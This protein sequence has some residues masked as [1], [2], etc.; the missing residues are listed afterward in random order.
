MNTISHK[1]TTAGLCVIALITAMMM[2]W[3]ASTF[4]TW[5]F[6]IACSL[7]AMAALLLAYS[8]DESQDDKL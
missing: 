8:M 2:I 1:K 6:A 4:W 7:A 3:H 5:M